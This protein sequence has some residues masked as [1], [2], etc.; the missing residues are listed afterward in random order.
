MNTRAAASTEEAGGST[1]VTMSWTAASDAYWAIAAVPIHP[2]PG[3]RPTREL[4]MQVG[5]GRRPT[6][7]VGTHT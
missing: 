2:L 7:A 3:R 4:T 1:L 5:H 6:P